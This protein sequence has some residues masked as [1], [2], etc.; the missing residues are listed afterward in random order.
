MAVTHKHGEGNKN[1]QT[2]EWSY[3]FVRADPLPGLCL[4][5]AKNSKREITRRF[6]H[7]FALQIYSWLKHK[8]TLPDELNLCLV[9]VVEFF[10]AICTAYYM[11]TFRLTAFLKTERIFRPGVLLCLP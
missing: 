1:I 7:Y 3:L 10:V 2:S 6:K 5:G 4:Q 9:K 11:R 8:S